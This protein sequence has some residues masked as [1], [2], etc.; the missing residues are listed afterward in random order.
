MG[1]SLRER[2]WDYRRDLQVQLA[3][4]QKE[5]DDAETIEGREQSQVELKELCEKVKAP[6]TPPVEEEVV[7]EE[8]TPVVVV[9]GEESAPEDSPAEEE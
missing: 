9:S 2:E 6:W 8:E 3:A 7:E 4:K 1:K 5:I